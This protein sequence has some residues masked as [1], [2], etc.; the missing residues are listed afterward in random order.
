M[1]VEYLLSKAL[2]QPISAIP[3]FVTQELT[4]LYP[5]KALLQCDRP[6]S[7]HLE[8]YARAGHCAATLHPEIVSQI[9]TRWESVE[10]GLETEAENAWFEITWQG[11]HLDA[12][13][14]TW[15]TGGCD[16]SR[17][18]ILADTGELAENFLAAVSEWTAEVRGEVLIFENGYWEKSEALFKAIQNATFDNLIL[19][20]GLKEEIQT[21]FAQFFASRQIYE[22]YRVP[23]K[24]GVL[25]IGPPGN[26]K[27]H[28]VKALI[29]WLGRPC[30]YVKSLKSRYETDHTNIRRIFARA[31]KTTPCL[32]VLEDLDSLLTDKNRSF[33]L[34]E[35]DGFA[36]NTGI[37]VLATTN[38]PERLDPAILER[39]SR[40]DRKY[41][42]ELPGLAERDAYLRAWNATL[43]P[44]LRLSNPV[45]T[46]TACRTEGFSFAYLKELFLSAMMRWIAARQPGGMDALLPAQIDFLREQMRRA[47]QE[48]S[49]ESS[50]DEDDED[51]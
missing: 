40:F 37:V 11:R 21:D 31:R 7:F 10:E 50:E 25:F 20:A 46:Q 19:P 13:K 15:N 17:Y 27:T 48:T 4:T 3:Y 51:S 28:T 44:A 39:P 38:H 8:A 22:C 6:Y 23:W 35:L 47:A 24:R 43:E 5:G 41:Y 1:N 12:L 29:N 30:L 9:A 34:N 2:S 42:F 36:A 26:G 32:L 18:W 33:F 49:P 16:E 14:L 45:I